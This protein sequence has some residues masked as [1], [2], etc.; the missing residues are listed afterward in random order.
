MLCTELQT[1]KFALRYYLKREI[2]YGM[3]S[4]RDVDRDP[5]GKTN[6]DCQLQLGGNCFE[7]PS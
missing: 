5:N 3:P 1:E 6:R 7:S 2:K 4:E